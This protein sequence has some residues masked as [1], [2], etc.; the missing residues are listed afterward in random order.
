MEELRL[1][2]DTQPMKYIIVT[3]SVLSGLGKGITISSMG[4]LLK[5]C[6]L[7]V[8]SI[9]IDPYLN[10]DAGVMSPFEHGETYVLDDGGETDL[11]LGNYERFLGLSLTRDHNITTGKIYQLV[12]NRE[13]KGEKG[14]RGKTVQV[15]PH[16]TDAIV[17][18]I[19]R[20]AKIS[21]EK[22][23]KGESVTP[24]I[25]LVE[26][27]GTVGDIES[28]VFLE[29]LRQLQRTVGR[30][31]FAQLHVSLVPVMEGEQKTKPVQHGV[32][33]LR[34]IGLL[35]DLIACRCPG[36]ALEFPTKKKISMFTDV[37]VDSIFSVHNVPNILAVPLL[38]R[39]QG[40][41]TVLAQRLG[42]SKIPSATRMSAPDI[43]QWEGIYTSATAAKTRGEVIHIAL[44][45]KYCFSKDGNTFMG[46]EAYKS[47][48]NALRHASVAAGVLLEI[49]WIHAD[50][51]LEPKPM[52]P[53]SPRTA[54]RA[55]K[56]LTCTT[57]SLPAMAGES[58]Q[59]RGYDN[60]WDSLKKADGLIVPGGF[61]GRGVEGIITAIQFA[62][63]RKMP[64][65]GICLG[66]QCAVIEHA[67][68]ALGWATA[69]SQEEEEEY[70]CAEEKGKKPYPVVV[71]MLESDS[72]VTMGGNMRLGTRPSDVQPDTIAARL[73]GT[74]GR[75]RTV[76]EKMIVDERHRHRY[77]INPDFVDELAGSGLQFVGRNFDGYNTTEAA[78]VIA[79]DAEAVA[80]QETPSP[81]RP[82]E[83][84][85][86]V[87]TQHQLAFFAQAEPNFRKSVSELIGCRV[88]LPLDVLRASLEAVY[89]NAGYT[90]QNAAGLRMDIVELS[91][92][93]HPFFFACQ[94]H[95][96]FKSTPYDPSPPFRGL[97]EAAI[98]AK[99]GPKSNDQM[100]PP[101]K[102]QRK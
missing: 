94:Y 47:V 25:C 11:D 14:Y 71:M 32:K 30:D 72:N 90:A 46:N 75:S 91:Q 55:V 97:M 12:I 23:S 18:W 53:M 77:E 93:T 21:V 98:K 89:D 60:A 29:A 101:A 45:G 85:G 99:G 83:F 37:P 63:E 95:P 8:T 50:D 13:R 20:V 76:D 61:G 41:H 22:N 34:S 36:R 51:L 44:V 9:K 15:V 65:F 74:P 24:D 52:T 4:V 48:A 27:G 66:M 84:M 10:V 92:D 39:D 31:N 73:Y 56:V 6:G 80:L 3:G 96:E 33:E 16:V 57:Q 68:S 2:Q 100:S 88:T 17:E 26:L 40:L 38:L 102:R 28:A 79:K 7:N 59:M 58:E 1:D 87:L 67:R 19:Q 64:F 62:R 49:V 5:A 78:S 54:A 86:D 43:S 69:H 35:P 81:H 82:G 70:E 42:L